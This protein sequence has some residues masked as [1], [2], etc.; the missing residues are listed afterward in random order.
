MTAGTISPPNKHNT[1]AENSYTRNPSCNHD[2]T[3]L[4]YGPPGCGKTTA[5]LN[6]ISGLHDRGIAPDEVAFSSFTRQARRVAQERVRRQ[7]DLSL[8]D[9]PHYRTL[10]AHA[11][12]ALGLKKGDVIG[13]RDWEKLA[14][15]YHYDFTLDALEHDRDEW[16]AAPATS[17]R[18]DDHLPA[19]YDWTRGR[20]LDLET[21][22]QQYRAQHADSVVPGFPAFQT[23]VTRYE[24]FKHDVERVDFTDM[25]LFALRERAWPAVKWLVLDEVQDNNPLMMAYCL[26]WAA[27]CEGLILAADPDQAIYTFAGAAPELFESVAGRRHEL[28]QSY[29][30][31]RTVHARALAIRAGMLRH[32]G[33]AYA[34]SEAAGEV[35]EILSPDYLDWKAIFGRVYDARQPVAVL[36]RTNHLLNGW[37]DRLLADGVPFRRIK[38]TSPLDDRSVN[39]TLYLIIRQ[40]EG[41][42]RPLLEDWL[43]LLEHVPVT[44]AGYM[45]RGTRE[46]VRQAC[47][48]NP[49]ARAAL[50]EL[51]GYG[52]LAPFGDAIRA[53]DWSRLLKV[54]NVNSKLLDYYRAVER[55]WS[56]D[57]LTQ[58]PP[59]ELSTIHGYKGG[60]ATHVILDCGISRRVDRGTDNDPDAE[61]RVGYVGV[62]R[63]AE[64][65]TFV[66]GTSPLQ[67]I[68]SF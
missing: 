50:D 6:R 9:V 4:I 23:F 59:V 27:E 42:G 1:A 54:G 63:A 45:K 22:Y 10:H 8:A 40:I 56:I 32:S 20:L 62:T 11:F 24:S 48:G 43:A 28:R 49:E 21:G 31:P 39:R 57:A 18:A 13:R 64:R 29:R 41:N 12:H 51:E 68:W 58:R 52:V 26:A 3:E 44:G 15:T 38:G 14:E 5:L 7:F 53:G 16:E 67:A 33:V 30:L 35:E 2:T 37:A 60:E 36:A 61:L 19:C 17:E 25:L 34:P 47:A 55:R 65:L 46:A 66:R